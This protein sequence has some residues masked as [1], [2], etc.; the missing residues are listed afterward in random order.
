MMHC[1][2][3][4]PSSVVS[5]LLQHCSSLRKGTWAWHQVVVEEPCGERTS[6]S[7]LSGKAFRTKQV[8]RIMIVR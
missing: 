5:G 7:G 4:R 2:V 1:D 3:G 8:I 6:F